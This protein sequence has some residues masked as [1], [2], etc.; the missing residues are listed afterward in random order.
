M[1]RPHVV[2]GCA[3]WQDTRSKASVDRL[4]RQIAAGIEWRISLLRLGAEKHIQLCC[5][6]WMTVVCNFRQDAVMVKEL[7]ED[8][9]S[10]I[11]PGNNAS[12]ASRLPFSCSIA[13]WQ[14]A[15]GLASE[16]SC[17]LLTPWWKIHSLLEK[18]TKLL[19]CVLTRSESQ[20]LHFSQRVKAAMQEELPVI[21]LRL[22]DD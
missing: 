15:P 20:A 6:L 17:L 9:S 3:L 12:F 5:L 18:T 13:R 14:S 2:R 7:I 21:W 22:S 10:W 19:V 8:W 4:R 16:T 11:W 1:T